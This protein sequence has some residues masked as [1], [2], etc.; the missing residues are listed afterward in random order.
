[1]QERCFFCVS[2]FKAWNLE[3]LGG[4]KFGKPLEDPIACRSFRAPP[5]ISRFQTSHQLTE[6]F[7]LVVKENTFYE[8]NSE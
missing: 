2:W 5:K 3:I 8:V 6:K 7:K 4:R 1:M